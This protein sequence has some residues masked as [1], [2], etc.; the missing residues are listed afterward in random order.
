MDRESLF[1]WIDHYPAAVTVC[2]KDGRIVAMNSRSI[3]AFAKHGGADLLGTSL[4]SCHPE[5]ANTIIRK[6]LA[7]ESSNTYIVQKGSTKKLVHQSPW[8][9]DG[10]FAG[11]VETVTE[12]PDELPVIVKD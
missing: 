5:S 1:D 8:F 12:L 9:K 11:L 2:D 3:S 7:T 4:F 10:H 6:L